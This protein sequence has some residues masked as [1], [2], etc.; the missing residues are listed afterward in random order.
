[1]P[2]DS[3]IALLRQL[4]AEAG[5][6][7]YLELLERETGM[8]QCST[9]EMLDALGCCLRTFENSLAKLVRKG[10]VTRVGKALA[11]NRGNPLPKVEESLS[12]KSGNPVQHEENHQN[13]EKRGVVKDL[14]LEVQDLK[15]K[16]T[17]KKPKPPLEKKPRERNPMI[18][19][20]AQAWQGTTELT[21]SAFKRCLK[22]AS[23]L[24]KTGFSSNDVPLIVD[25]IR[26]RDPWRS[27]PIS[28]QTICE[29]APNWR[30]TRGIVPS[31]TKKPV[32][33]YRFDNVDAIRERKRQI[34][35]EIIREYG[36]DDPMFAGILELGR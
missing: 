19:A 29:N 8:A 1:M 32:D 13:H 18:D 35:Q 3:F 2:R 23:E 9:G 30:A 4:P 20:I 17:A 22:P 26:A 24:S 16:T 5:L 11:L 21:E 6:I 27:G 14:D 10:L 34:E 28:P 12:S 25:F 7:A 15:N 36:L 31:Q 33:D